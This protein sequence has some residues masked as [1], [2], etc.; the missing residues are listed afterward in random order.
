MAQNKI[1]FQ[2]G[3][4]IRE[5]VDMYGTEEQCRTAPEKFR[6]PDGYFRKECGHASCCYIESRKV[7]QCNRCHCQT[8][9]AGGTVFHS[10]NL[11]STKWF[12]ATVLLVRSRNGISS[13]E[14]KRQIGVSYPTAFKL[15]HKPMRAMAE[16]DSRKSLS[17]PIEAGD[18]YLG[19]KGRGGKRGRGAK[20]QQPFL[21]AVEPALPENCNDELGVKC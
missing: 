14:P 13:L 1:Q 9:V 18:A 20:G 15:G 17:G 7:F 10:T 21:A 19:G 16:R 4:G 5:F 6:W 2:K 11:P 3:I 8:S 12:P